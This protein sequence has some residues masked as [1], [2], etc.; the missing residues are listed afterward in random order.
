MSDSVTST[1]RKLLGGENF[2]E[3]ESPS[4]RLE[5]YVQFPEKVQVNGKW[6]EIHKKNEE[7]CSVVK[8]HA[9]HAKPIPHFEPKGCVPFVAKLRSRLIVNQAGGILENAGLCLHPHFGAPYIPGS[10]VKGIA[11]HA[12]WCE[13]NTEKDKDKK[14]SIAERFAQVF[15]YPTGDSRPKK[16]EEATRGDPDAYLDDYLAARGWKD[17][18]SSGAV[19]FL[20]AVPCSEK[21]VSDKGKLDV[22]IV[23][24]HQRAYYG[25]RSREASPSSTDN[26]NPQ[27]FPTVKD[28]VC[29]RFSIVPVRR[30]NEELLSFAKDWLWKALEE[31]GAG[32]K[33]AA[34]YGWFDLSDAREEERKRAEKERSERLSSTIPEYRSKLQP[35]ASADYLSADQREQLTVLFS[36][37]NAEN[38]PV[39]KLDPEYAKA[40]SIFDTSVQV[41]A[42]RNNSQGSSARPQ[43]VPPTERGLP[44]IPD[45]Y[46]SADAFVLTEILPFA[47]PACSEQ[48]RKETVGKIVAAIEADCVR[49]GWS[50][51][52][53]RD[54][55]RIAAIRRADGSPI[56]RKEKRGIE[57]SVGKIREWAKQHNVELP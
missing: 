25:S 40:K 29:F 16:D 44:P 41:D 17:K 53:D 48:R 18:S 22:D 10:A 12:A 54:R 46:E 23:N 19:A 52:K 32:A 31:N 33:T 34:G 42:M 55:E 49:T 24:V 9:K 21:A 51:V 35:F 8:C 4:L 3:C 20:P 39:S 37:I 2:P 36:E 6:E 45:R 57:V 38:V 27:S 26:L 15:G 30:G 14:K 28:G 1:V 11:R 13:W 5:K 50:L 43:P 7:I 56:A 47:D